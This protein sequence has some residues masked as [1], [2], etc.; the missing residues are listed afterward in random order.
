MNFFRPRVSDTI[1]SSSVNIEEPIVDQ[2]EED[3]EV[4][5]LHVEMEF[6]I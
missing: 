2:I 5:E 4:L 6:G 1:A 3:V